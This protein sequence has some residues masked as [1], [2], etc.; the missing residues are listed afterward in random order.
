MNSWISHYFQL[1]DV[2]MDQNLA[3]SGQFQKKSRHFWT[4]HPEL[5]YAI[6]QSR[7]IFYMQY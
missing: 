2:S 4:F 6:M 7:T 5:Y 3:I 1:K